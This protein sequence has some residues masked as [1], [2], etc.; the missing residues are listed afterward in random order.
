M[1]SK[2]LKDWLE[3]DDKHKEEFRADKEKLI[4]VLIEKGDD[5]RIFESDLAKVTVVEKKTSYGERE[6]IP[7]IQMSVSL[8]DETYTF[9]ERQKAPLQD[10]DGR[11]SGDGQG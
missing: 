9:E 8:F 6:S 7:G 1:K 2:E 3:E 10:R 11:R 4:A 5:C